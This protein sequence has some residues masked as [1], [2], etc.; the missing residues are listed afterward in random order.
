MM[1]RIKLLGVLLLFSIVV[2]AQ[3]SSDGWIHIYYLTND[4]GNEIAKR[5]E[6]AAKWDV[7]STS[8]ALEKM[9][10]QKIEAEK[11]YALVVEILKQL[12]PSGNPIDKKKYFTAVKEYNKY[13]NH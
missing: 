5:F 4:S 3:K 12:D 1:K 7:D 11:R 6:G 8:V 13:L 2:L 9:Y 10:Q